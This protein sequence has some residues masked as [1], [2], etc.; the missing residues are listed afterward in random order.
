MR[1]TTQ[2]VEAEAEGYIWVERFDR[3]LQDIF[4]LRGEI[5][6]NIRAA[7]APVLGLLE[8]HHTLGKRTWNLTAWDYVMRSN[9]AAWS[10]DYKSLKQARHFPK[11]ALELPPS[12]A[13]ALSLVAMSC[14][15]PA[16]KGLSDSP[17]KDTVEAIR[18][19][20][21][22]FK[23]NPRDSS[24]LCARSIE[25]PAL[26][27]LDPA[28]ESLGFTVRYN[29]N[30]IYP[31]RILAQVLC[32]RG[33]YVEAILEAELSLKLSPKG[34]NLSYTEFTLSFATSWT[35]IQTRR[36]IGRASLSKESPG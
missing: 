10:C 8:V 18:V 28:T 11:G 24:S 15:L 5:T 14:A 23:G 12:Y 29:P 20:A 2:L 31:R 16:S 1:I 17:I 34:V 33:Q 3:E 26:R 9:S 13:D 6:K 19:A 30:A 25:D 36:H 35:A 21:I 32:H 4:E 7:A 22:A 27:N